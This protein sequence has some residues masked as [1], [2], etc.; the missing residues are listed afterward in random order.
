MCQPFSA[1][2]TVTLKPFYYEG[3][4][5]LMPTATF[6]RNFLNIPTPPTPSS[7]HRA[8]QTPKSLALKSKSIIIKIQVPFDSY[9]S[10]PHTTNSGPLLVYTKKRDF[11]CTILRMD[12]PTGYDKVVEVV[13]AKGVGGAKAY[14]AAEL[15]SED[16]LV[17]KISEVLAEQPF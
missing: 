5:T 10:M 6:V 16:V 15:K 14:F 3:H 11:A 17:V 12:N 8:A 9:A 1:E 2:N 4:Q 13:K 7:H